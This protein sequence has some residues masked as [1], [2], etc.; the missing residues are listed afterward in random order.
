MKLMGR[1][2]GGVGG[3]H[4]VYYYRFIIS[5]SSIHVLPVHVLE[6]ANYL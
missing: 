5:V 3:P 4:A 2:E 1:W 6:Q